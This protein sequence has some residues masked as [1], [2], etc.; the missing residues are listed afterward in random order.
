MRFFIIALVL[1]LCVG[2]ISAKQHIAVQNIIN[3]IYSCQENFIPDIQKLSDKDINNL[4]IQAVNKLSNK[5]ININKNTLLLP[6]NNCVLR[7]DRGYI[8][9]LKSL[10]DNLFVTRIVNFDLLQHH[11]HK[12]ISNSQGK[13]DDS[14]IYLHFNSSQYPQAESLRSLV[15]VLN[16]MSEARPH[17]RILLT[18]FFGLHRTGLVSAIYQFIAHYSVDDYEACQHYSVEQDNIYQFMT[19]LSQQR[20]SVDIPFEYKQFYQDFVQAV[21]DERSHEFLEGL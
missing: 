6:V 13:L 18:C 7:S 21:C 16:Y 1:S 15:Q 4:F 5:D 20:Q 14:Y 17:K 10:K 2:N 3:N 8:H 19:E 11:Q 9:Y 12:D